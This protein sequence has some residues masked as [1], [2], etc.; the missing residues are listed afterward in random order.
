[1]RLA[2]FA[3]QQTTLV[4]QLA[5]LVALQTTFAALH[6]TPA[7]GSRRLFINM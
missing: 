5:A 1:V 3:A 6:A 4:A 2:A 7:A